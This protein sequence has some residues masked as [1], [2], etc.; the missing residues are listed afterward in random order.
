MKESIPASQG[1]S[2]LRV[3]MLGDVHLHHLPRTPWSLIGK[4]L[5]GAANL[6]RGRRKRFQ[7]HLMAMAINRILALRPDQVWLTGDL[8]TLSTRREFAEARSLI[9]P[10][11]ERIPAV[12]VPGNHD[13]YT[14]LA[15]WQRRAIHAWGS[16][17]AMP[18]Q[19]PLMRPIIGPWHL[20]AIDSCAPRLITSRGRIRPATLDAIGKLVSAAAADR[21]VRERCLAV[22]CHYPA[23]VPGGIAQHWQ[24]RLAGAG[25]LVD[26]LTAS[27]GRILMIHG[28]IHKTWLIRGGEARRVDGRPLTGAV[29]G[30]V[31][32]NLGSPTMVGPQHPNGQGFWLV[33]FFEQAERMPTFEHHQLDE[34]ELWQVRRH[35]EPWADVPGPGTTIE[36]G[37]R[38]A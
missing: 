24:H 23:V 16:L 31:D 6:L 20:L 26:T 32:L 33:E 4:R 2:S 38:P 14:F 27:A 10:L 25:P 37:N 36:T 15:A 19:A 9:Q 18:D 3:A 28:H 35:P 22:L 30:L 8:T 13:C 1:R 7:P 21:P 11:C 5:L 12:L 29:R 34:T 17:V